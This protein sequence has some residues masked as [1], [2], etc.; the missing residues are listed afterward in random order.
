MKWTLY[1]TTYITL[2]VNSSL[3]NIRN[4][5]NQKCFQ[6]GSMRNIQTE[7]YIVNIRVIYSVTV[8]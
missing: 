8:L 4:L 5:I 2:A 7:N 6:A 1:W 3:T